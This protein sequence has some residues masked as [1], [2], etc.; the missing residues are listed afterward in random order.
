[1]FLRNLQMEEHPLK[2]KQLLEYQH[3]LLLRDILG[4]CYKTNTTVIYCHFRLHHHRNIY[5]TLKLPWNDGKLLQ[6]DSKLL[7]YFNPRNNRIYLPW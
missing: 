7:Q 1:M 5:I 3:F 6:Y 2:C 4:Q